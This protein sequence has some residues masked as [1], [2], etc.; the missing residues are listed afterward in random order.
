MGRTMPVSAAKSSTRASIKLG[1]KTK[2]AWAVKLV[3]KAWASAA[4]KFPKL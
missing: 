2:L 3:I 4:A 1:S